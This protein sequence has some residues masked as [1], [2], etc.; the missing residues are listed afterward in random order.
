MAHEIIDLKRARAAL[1][2]SINILIEDSVTDTA[3]LDKIKII[4]S[5]Y[6]GSCSLFIHLLKDGKTETIKA[7]S[8]RVAPNADMI[9]SLRSLLGSKRVWIG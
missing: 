4:V 1:S 5:K 8:I 9:E 2:K 6:N 3:V 7:R